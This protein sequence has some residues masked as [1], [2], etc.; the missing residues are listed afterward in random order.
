[1]SVLVKDMEMPR[2]CC[3]CWL[4]SHDL[5]LACGKDAEDWFEGRP[6]YCPLVEIPENSYLIVGTGKFSREPDDTAEERTK[7]VLKL[8][9][10]VRRG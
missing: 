5:C 9:N 6:S 4:S 1:M 2:S 10:E 7:A 3:M 8:L